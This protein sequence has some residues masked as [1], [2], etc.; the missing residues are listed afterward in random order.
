M[1]VMSET[2]T[3]NNSQKTEY[4]IRWKSG[5]QKIQKYIVQD[6]IGTVEFSKQAGTVAL[7]TD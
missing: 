7:Q 4:K 5:A 3:E 1:G 2:E 6:E